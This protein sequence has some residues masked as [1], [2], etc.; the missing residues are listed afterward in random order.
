MVRRL[1]EPPA[2]HR[3][4][5]ELATR[6]GAK[7][8]ADTPREK[9]GTEVAHLLAEGRYQAEVHFVGEENLQGVGVTFARQPKEFAER[10]EHRIEGGYSPRAARAVGREL[11][12]LGR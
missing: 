9:P 8:L 4:P 2:V 12:L 3:D 6:V 5:F 7:G 1:E 10:E 11:Q